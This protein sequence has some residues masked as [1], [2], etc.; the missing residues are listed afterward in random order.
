MDAGQNIAIDD[1]SRNL[2]T[3]RDP[4]FY[5]DDN[6]S[7]TFLIG[8]GA[9]Q[10]SFQTVLALETGQD[11]VSAKGSYNSVA[12]GNIYQANI[13]Y[14]SFDTGANLG[15]MG[16]YTVTAARG[17]LQTG[18]FTAVSNN[19]YLGYLN[20]VTYTGSPTEVNSFQQLASI[21]FYATGSNALG[22]LG[23][24]ISMW[25][26]APVTTGNL[27][28]QAVGIE[29]DQSTK[30]FGNVTMAGAR[31]DTGYQYTAPTT[32]FGNVQVYSN[33]SRFIMDPSGSI[34]NGNIRLPSVAPDGAVIKVSSTQTITN[35]SFW[36]LGATTIVPS[37]NVTLTGGTSIEFFYHASENKWYKVA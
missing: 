14:P 37:A 23:G 31:F 30:F 29:N 4:N 12:V 3:M 11:I 34:T 19:D 27:M 10:T 9:N 6:V 35:F 33:I 17:N 28:V 22:G 32:N 24:N 21:G 1:L 13:N 5:W 8:Y 36:A 18:T 20:S 7:P 25:T 15:I 2:S 26:H 16:G